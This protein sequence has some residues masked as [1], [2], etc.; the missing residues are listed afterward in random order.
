ME[1]DIHSGNLDFAV[2]FKE[3]RQLIEL[4]IFEQPQKF[5]SVLKSQGMTPRI[6]VLSMIEHAAGDYLQSGSRD[7]FFPM[8]RGKLNCIGS[9]GIGQNA[10]PVK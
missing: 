10:F 9:T 7:Y 8:S 6:K 4:T 5:I 1:S 2:V 3:M